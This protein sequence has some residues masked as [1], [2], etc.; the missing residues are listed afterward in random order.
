MSDHIKT[1]EHFIDAWNE[2]DLDKIMSFFAADCLYHNIPMDPIQGVDEIRK[3]IEGFIGMS[4]EIAWEVH[5]IAETAKGA[6]L[7]ERTDKFKLG[8]RWIALPV[9]GTFEIEDGKFVAWR[10]YFDAAQF[11]NQMAGS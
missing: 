9:M 11:Q 10:D 7:T 6:V 8:E 2:R 3:F 5:Q 4:S 1:V